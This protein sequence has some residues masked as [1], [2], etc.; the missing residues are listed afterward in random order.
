MM[1]NDI[2][3]PANPRIRA[4]AKLRDRRERDRTGLTVVDGT[5]E[6]QRAL[7]G[8]A[9]VTEAFVC[10]ALATSADA[11][12]ALSAL[13]SAGIRLTAVSAA[14]F[15]KIAFGDRAEGIVAVVRPPS[16]ELASL[17]LPADPLV[18]VLEAVEKPGN[19][20]AALRS[21]DGAGADA[22]IAA[23]PN[24][25]VFNP[26]TIRASAGTVFSVPIAAAPT[27]DVLAFLRDS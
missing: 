6:I 17:R 7:D 20:G 27:P 21:A 8:R 23:D 1:S 9:S 13:E 10:A 19:L 12:R 16:A 11:R 14:A 24:T 3:S 26:N 25:D 2:A 15:E 4:V 22:V 5:R 18:V